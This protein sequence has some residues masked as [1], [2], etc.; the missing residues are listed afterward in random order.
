MNQE[1]TQAATAV[2]HF[3]ALLS[4]TR[5]GARLAW[6]LTERQLADWGEPSGA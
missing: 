1:I 5:R 3:T 4:A 6:L 2:R